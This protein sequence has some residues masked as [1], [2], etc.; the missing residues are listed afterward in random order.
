MKTE[1]IVDDTKWTEWIKTT[2]GVKIFI[3]SGNSC[4]FKIQRYLIGN[5]GYKTYIMIHVV[6]KVTIAIEDFCTPSFLF[7]NIL[8]IWKVTRNPD[9]EN[10]EN[11]DTSSGTDE[12]QKGKESQ[13]TPAK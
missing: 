1:D 10:R 3:F 5:Y 4:F 7:G 12:K 8:R 9:K 13:E 6:E 11:D 2:V